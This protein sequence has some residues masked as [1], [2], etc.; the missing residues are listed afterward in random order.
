MDTKVY[1]GTRYQYGV[2]AYPKDPKDN[3]NLGLVGPLK[4]TVR[5]TTRT[6]NSV[7]GGT[8]QLTAQWTGSSNFTGYQVQIATNSAFTQNVQT[9]TIGNPKT[10]QTTIKNLKAATT[11]Y[12]RVR[13]YQVFE[14]VTYYGGWSN[15][16]SA[17][18]NSGPRKSTGETGAFSVACMYVRV[19][20]LTGINRSG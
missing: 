11:Y 2:K 15:V 8:K 10:Y 12:V 18:R 5:I 9:V 6:L 17:K 7:T 3:Y 16:K 19:P 20:L 13:S 4:T 14:G 1:A